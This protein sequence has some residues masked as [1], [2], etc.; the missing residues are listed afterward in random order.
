MLLDAAQSYA[1]A[2]QEDP[3]QYGKHEFGST[4][5][6]MCKFRFFFFWNCS[7]NKIV[8]YCVSTQ[9]WKI[10]RQIIYFNKYDQ[11]YQNGGLVLSIIGT[12]KKFQNQKLPILIFWTILNHWTTVRGQAESLKVRSAKIGRNWCWPVW[13][14]AL[15]WFKTTFDLLKKKDEFRL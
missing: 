13:H 12:H 3:S 8:K 7:P 10:S 5:F 15:H 14:Q 11:R 9:F 2:Y 4:F 1:F 6:H